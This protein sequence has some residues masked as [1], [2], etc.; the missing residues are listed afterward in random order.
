M[1]K[2]SRKRTTGPVRA[3]DL[4]SA[5]V[6]TPTSSRTQGRSRVD[7]IIERAEERP[8]PPWHPIPLVEL[9]VL[10]GI[11]LLVVGIINREDK[12]GR[13]AILFG[14]SLASLAGLETAAREH[15]SGFRSHSSLLAGLPT[16]MVA[17]VMGVVGVDIPIVLPAAVLVFVICFFALRGSFKRKTGVAFKV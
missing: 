7:R 8:K 11:V 5:P 13:L 9:S 1:G 17:L 6:R 12:Q 2:R 10:F 4:T 3:P 16:V 15:F 14:I